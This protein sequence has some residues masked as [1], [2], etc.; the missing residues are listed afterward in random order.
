V[1]RYQLG[2]ALTKT[3]QDERD[4]AG[5][6]GRRPTSRQQQTAPETPIDENTCA[7]G[8]R[9]AQETMASKQSGEAVSTNLDLVW[10]E[11]R[12]AVDELAHLVHLRQQACMERMDGACRSRVLWPLAAAVDARAAAG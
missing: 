1:P 8:W 9:C 10:E 2:R 5:R 6:R 7:L 11:H 3:V 4:Y 12:R